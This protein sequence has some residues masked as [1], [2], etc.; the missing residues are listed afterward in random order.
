MTLDIAHWQ[1]RLALLAE[2]HGVPGANLAI[3][4]GDEVAAT[5]YG[6]L[7]VRTGVAATTDSLFQIGSITKVWTATLV[8]QLVD[9][10]LVDLDAPVVTYLPDFQ[11]AD[12]D[13]TR[14]VTTRHL[15]AHTS[16]IDGDFF[17]DTGRGDDSV[18]KYVAACATL[19]QN[20]PLGATMSYC[21][22][23]YTVLG[24]LVEVLRGKS[25]DAV[26]RERLFAPLGLTT[27]GTLPEEALLHSAAVGHVTPPGGEPQVAPAWGIF[28]SAGP[29]GLIHATPRDVITF[30][31]LHLNDGVAA[32]GTRVLSAESAQAMREEQVRVPDEYTLGSHWGLGWIL[33]TWDGH[34]VYGH[35]GGTIGQS[36]FLRIVPDANIAICLLTNGGHTQDLFRDLFGEILAE[37]AGIQVPSRLEPAADAPAFDPAKYVGTYRREGVVMTIAEKD[38]GLVLTAK[39]TGELAEMLDRD[40]E[41]ELQVLPVA[42]DLFVAK[43]PDD[44]SWTP[45]VFFTLDDGSPY[46]HFGARATP[47]VSDPA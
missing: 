14:Q 9:E 21:N 6:V 22:S 8:M 46:V 15:L 18:E 7:N 41:P 44:T 16:G 31:E 4:Q 3:K 29:A 25:W 26:L 5:A 19:G 42:E 45:V 12:P 32:D 43:Q 11:V 38:G 34:P 28:R 2:K 24:R 1:E 17:L 27:A 20:H 47:K 33:M 23:G 40:E 10:G 36:A 30:A 37:L 13:V 39:A 35:D